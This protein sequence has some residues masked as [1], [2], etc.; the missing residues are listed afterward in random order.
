[1]AVKRVKLLITL[2]IIAIIV[3]LI[4]W[5]GRSKPIKDIVTGQ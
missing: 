4:A 3:T 5:F 1:M 2:L